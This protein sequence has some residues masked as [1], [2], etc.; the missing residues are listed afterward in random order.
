ME[1]VS[2]ESTDILFF[3]MYFF[4]KVRTWL[5]K[6]IN[7]IQL[8]KRGPDGRA[9]SKDG[10]G[11]LSGDEKPKPLRPLSLIDTRIFACFFYATQK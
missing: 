7:E 3:M 4:W 1:H 11:A 8:G 6:E 10:P 9:K 2:A 5:N